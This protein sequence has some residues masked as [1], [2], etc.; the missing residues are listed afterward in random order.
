MQDLL[1]FTK[2]DLINTDELRSKRIFQ[3]HGGHSN[4]DILNIE[5]TIGV[6]PI[7]YKNKIKEYDFYGKLIGYFSLYP[8]KDSHEKMAS[9][10]I[11]ANTEHGIL[12]QD[13]LK[14]QNLICI[15][16]RPDYTVC[17]ARQ[18]K[19]FNEDQI[20]LIDD[21]IFGNENNPRPEDIQVVAD[22]IE[23]FLLIIGNLNQLHREVDDDES[24]YDEKR[25]EFINRLRIL[26]VNEKY[27]DFWKLLF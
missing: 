12:S 11:S 7:N 18:S 23:Q 16:S 22:N 2:E 27:Y 21:E 13:F 10:L 5:K 19:Y 20:V 4:E 17:V 24:N 3:G 25:D 1:D 15:G 26:N 14:E 8:T 6:L 9:S